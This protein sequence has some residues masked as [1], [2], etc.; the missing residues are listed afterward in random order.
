MENV[1]YVHIEFIF[2][3][4]LMLRD[5]DAATS[6]DEQLLEVLPPLLALLQVCQTFSFESV[7]PSL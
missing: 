2:Q 5:C 7:P 6:R 3:V 1:R 4:R